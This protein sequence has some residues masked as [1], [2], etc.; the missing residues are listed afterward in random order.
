MKCLVTGAAGFIGSHLAEAL[1]VAG[2]DVVGIDGFL[3]NYSRQRKL[4]QVQQL[5]QDP[6]FRLVEGRIQEQE[7]EPLLEG[8]DRVYH[9]AALPGVR[10]SWGRAF[11]HYLDH[12]VL[13]TQR[14]LEACLEARVSRFVYASSSSVYGDTDR[15]PMSETAR[16]RPFSPYGVSKLAAEQMVRL[17]YRNFGLATVS[18]RYF[19]VY[20]PRQRPDMAIQ[21]FL[22]AALAG[23]PVILFGDGE[24]GRDF[25]FV[26]DAV[27]ATCR[28][29][30]MGEPGGVYNV[31]G[32][33]HVSLNELIAAIQE[34]S[35]ARLKVRKEAAKPGDVRFTQADGSLARSVLGF[36]PRTS[37]EDGL[38]C[39]WAWLKEADGVDS[40]G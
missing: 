35:G 17:Y 24:Q 12:N 19:T 21:R 9:L 13:A 11:E 25:T 28:A 26:A 39:Q 27:S 32:G 37:L 23:E 20:G 33:S 29:A 14:L 6:R 4:S 10:P 7:L 1:L 15:L 31:G 40:R 34:V 38:A 5:R 2:A 8:V 16:T 18:V 36:V 30:D 3:D 22:K